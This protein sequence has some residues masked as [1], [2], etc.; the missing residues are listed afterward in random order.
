MNVRT[1]D[2][3]E[4][5]LKILPKFTGGLNTNSKGNQI[6]R[7]SG[8]DP[9]EDVLILFVPDLEGWIRNRGQISRKISKK[10]RRW[11]FRSINHAGELVAAADRFE[12]RTPNKVIM[13]LEFCLNH[14]PNVLDRD[15]V[16]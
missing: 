13:T 11:R 16:D 14:T 1:R 3:T 4:S 6:L 15:G 10:L 12:Q 8:I 9:N 7:E 5:L 2:S